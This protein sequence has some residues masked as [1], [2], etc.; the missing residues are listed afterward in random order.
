VCAI[1]ILALAGMRVA[2]QQRPAADLMVETDRAIMQEIDQSN[3]IM[4]NLEYISD[5]IGARLTG[6]E[7]MNQASRWTMEMFQKYGVSAKLEPWSIA[8]SWHRGTAWARIVSPAEHP[9]ILASAGWSP[10]TAGR[11]RGPVVYVN[12]RRAEDLPQYKGKLKGAIVI[13]AAPGRLPEPY[14]LPRS[15]LMTAPGGPAATPTPAEPASPDAPAQPRERQ[16]QFTRARD[17]FFRAEGVAAVLRDSVKEHGLI[18]MTGVGGRDYDIGAVP[19]AFVTSEG[20]RLIWRLLWRGAPKEVKVVVGGP[21]QHGLVELEI[22]MKNTFSEKPVEVYNTVAEI[23]GS[24]KPDEIVIIGAHLDSWDL[25]TGTTDNATGSMVVLEAARAL[26]KLNLKP[27]RTIRFVLFSGE[28][29]G[30]VG[31]RV[32]V[33]AHKDE[34]PKISA[35]LVHDTGTGR[36]QSIGMQGNYQARE[37]IDRVVAP[38]RGVGLL[39]ASLRSTR[40]TDHASFNDA[41]V[42]GFYCIQDPAEYRKTHH[43]ESDTFDK[44]WKDDLVQGAKVLAV[45]AYNVAQL[46]DLLPRRAAQTQP[47]TTSQE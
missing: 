11:V 17:A 22:E 15:P 25:G 30:L 42:P 44:A 39:E 28:E 46:P 38:L 47:V 7:K 10:G 37:V 36:V 45:W 19:T 40:G 20:Y 2:G 43:T 16:Q 4:A 31:S 35:V 23:R 29:Q 33:E 6:T 5:M 14:E 32:Y 12:A 21:P 26:Q 41:G 8:R 24:E 1:A 18:N 13:T 34:L 27:K 9:L 3:E